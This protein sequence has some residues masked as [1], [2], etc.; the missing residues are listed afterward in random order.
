LS[1]PA[2]LFVLITSDMSRLLGDLGPKRDNSRQAARPDRG[3]AHATLPDVELESDRRFTLPAPPDRVWQV[4]AETD[5]YR[6]WWPWLTAFE[7]D[8]LVA[9]DVWR[10]TVRPPLRYS[11][12]FAVHLEEVVQPTLVTA[13]LTGDIAGHARLDLAA[14]DDGTEVR[15]TSVLAPSSRVFA[16]FAVVARPLVRHGH[17]W[18][19]D[20]GVRQFVGRAIDGR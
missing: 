17:D 2:T 16:V 4:L 8:G 6:H 14:R 10:C 13:R 3:V 11:L 1:A 19:L 9:G 15:L 20:T 12:R 18:V 7:T 5:Q